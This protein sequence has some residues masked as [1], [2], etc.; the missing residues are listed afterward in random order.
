[1]VNKDSIYSAYETIKPFIRKT[2]LEFSRTLSELT[3][4]EIFLKLECLQHTGSFKARG[5]FNSFADLDLERYNGII[6]PTAGN[7]GIGLSFAASKFKIP[8]HIYLAEDADPIKIKILESQ[9]AIVKRFPD[10]ETA[11]FEA[12]VAAKKRKLKF[13]SAYNNDEMVN[14]GGTVAIEILQDLKDVDII[15]VPVGGGGL[16][17]GI[18]KF[19]KS[20]NPDCMIWGVQT[21]NSPTFVRW[22]DMKKTFQVDLKPSIAHGLS[23]FVEEDTI[24]FPIIKNN[25]NRM[26]ELDENHLID[27]MRF[28]AE[29][30]QLIVEPSGIAAV[31]A[32]MQEGMDLSGKK[33][34]SVVT[35]RNISFDE[36]NKLIQGIINEPHNIKS[37]KK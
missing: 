36:F 35:G 6:A 21:K 14:G 19:I 32:L 8:V 27:G 18:S 9:N 10:F 12:G 16:I 2:P 15:V 23:G 1:M 25:V 4:S 7:H 20:I 29:N 22:F 26:I 24:T 28:M 31:S 34:V 11:H 5:A 30:H 17:A 37:E 33:V 13:I 3:N